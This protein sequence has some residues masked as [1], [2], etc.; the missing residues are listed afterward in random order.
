M[1]KTNILSTVITPSHWRIQAVVGFYYGTKK[2]IRNKY[3]GG[4]KF[5]EYSIALY[6]KILGYSYIKLKRIQRNETGTRVYWIASLLPL[7]LVM[8]HFITM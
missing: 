1:L 5:Y 8:K 4:F 3:Q 2:N 6:I 7:Q